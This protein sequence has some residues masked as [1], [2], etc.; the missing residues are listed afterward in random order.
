MKE[1]L[2][3]IFSPIL[4]SFEAESGEYNYKKS[5]R[6]ILIAVGV[7]FLI[8]MSAVVAAGVVFSQP[9]AAIP[10]IVFM[11]ASTVCLV[12]GFLGSDRAVSKIWG[13]K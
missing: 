7:L 11:G 12:V 1:I 5:Y 2:K 10:G 6:I 8:L 4:N 13:R 9:G 3:K